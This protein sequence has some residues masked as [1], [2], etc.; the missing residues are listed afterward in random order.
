MAGIVGMALEIG[1]VDLGGDAADHAAGAARQEELDLDMAEQRILPGREA[2]R[3][4]TSR[5]GM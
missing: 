4:S 1:V 3:R 2:S 5:C